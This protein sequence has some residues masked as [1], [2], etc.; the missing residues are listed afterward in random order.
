VLFAVFLPRGWREGLMVVA[1][2]GA[3]LST[4]PSVRAANG[5]N[6]GPIR[7]VAWLFAGIFATMVPALHYLERNA[8]RLGADTGLE[9]FWFT[10]ALSS[11][12]DNAPTYLTFLAAALGRQGL[13]IQNPA[14]VG[15]F[16]VSHDHYLMAISMGAV[17]FGAM[18]YIGNGPNFMVKAIAEEA[19]V[20]VPGFVSYFL[21]FALPVLVPV[22][23]VVGI[24][25]FSDWRVF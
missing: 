25:F 6:F 19:K 11:V 4:R 1:A 20:N 12:L 3:H 21:R 8:G 14:D 16:A 15:A 24:L 5:F 7:E 10:G 9:Y 18:T 17:F 23:A 13:S 22:F 2:A